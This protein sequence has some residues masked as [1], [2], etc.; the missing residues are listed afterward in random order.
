[1][2]GTQPGQVTVP[3]E[4]SVNCLSCHSGADSA[5]PMEMWQG[6]M[7]AQS[8]KDPLFWAALTVAAQD[9]IWLEGSAEGADL[10]L[11]CH[12]PGGWLAGRSTPFNGS[13]MTDTDFEGVSCAFCHRMVDPFFQDTF[14]RVRECVGPGCD[15]DTYWDEATSEAE[16]RALTT[17]GYD[18]TVASHI[19]Y[20]DGDDFYGIDHRPLSSGYTENSSGQYFISDEVGPENV[21][22][23]ASF[24]DAGASEGVPHDFLYSRYHRSRN[25]CSTC[26][27]VSNTFLAN[28]G[29]EAEDPLPSEAASGFSYA[30]AERTFSEF[31]LS[32]FGLDGG[33][34]G[35]GAFAP[36]LFSTS[37][38]DNSIASC[39]DCHMPDVDGRACSLE[40]ASVLRPSESVAHPQTGAPSHDMTGANVWMSMILASTRSTSPNYD[41]VNEVYLDDPGSLT[42]DLYGGMPIAPDELIDGANRALVNLQRAGAIEKAD[43]SPSSGTLTFRVVNRTGHKLIS[44]YPE[45]RRMWVNV[46]LYDG[47]STL[48]HE[49]NPYDEAMD[50]L[51]GLPQR[52][53]G[54]YLGAN[55]SYEDS[56]VYEAQLGSSHTGESYS[57][58]FLLSDSFY[59]DNRIPPRGFRIAEAADRLIVPVSG[60]VVDPSYFTLEE[61]AG[62][63]DQVTLSVPPGAARAEIRLYYQVTS[64]EYVEFLQN[65]INGTEGETT[66]PDPE[67]SYIVQGNPFFLDLKIW[68][69]TIWNLWHH[70]RKDP[71]AAPILMTEGVTEVLFADGFESG[72]TTAW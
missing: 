49:V 13:S 68:G 20:A 10:C 40:S 33:A 71:G 48:M 6:S 59:K 29:H 45:G 4:S 53:D 15:W 46:Q 58:H 16:T 9:S 69:D 66:L 60:G 27:D 65:E 19:K 37:R 34:L 3:I 52:P 5:K 72:D 47:S 38:L 70:N 61:Y 21:H 22:R 11:R 54:P 55:E 63:Y 12:M 56:I 2:P 39:Q 35:E 57:Q 32:D 50:T 62:G 18:E 30:H 28:R 44:G 25:F 67:T 42:M 24:A 41:P 14:D 31:V 26:H 64:R 36:E 8:A 17:K 43:Y 7:M 1:M 23:R 51:R